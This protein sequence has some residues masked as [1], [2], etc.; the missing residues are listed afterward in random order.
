MKI[1]TWNIL[2]SEWIKKS[3][4]PTVRDQTL[5]NPDNRIHIIIDKLS[6]ESADIV[7]L[8]VVMPMEYKVLYQ[9]FN[10]TYRLSRLTPIQWS[11]TQST[12]S[13]SQSGNVTLVKKRIFDTWSESSFDHGIYVRI[14]QLH[15]F[16]IHLDDTSHY[17]RKKQLDQILLH[18]K[19][20]VVLAGDFNQP[21]KDTHLY[22]LPG[23]I[24]HN[25]CNTY[26]VEKNM[27]IDNI[28]T[29]GLKC[30]VDSCQYLPTSVEEGLSMYGSDH[31]PVTATVT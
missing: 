7:F 28:L 5:F 27:N 12:K 18:D 21:Y 29:K 30:S 16:N 19:K 6:K 15:L 1:L 11:K 17:K 9:K 22:Q 14:D 2:A 13:E 24:V 23:F 20:Y 31:I 25:L 10:R 3:Y 26:F 8:Q 4:Y